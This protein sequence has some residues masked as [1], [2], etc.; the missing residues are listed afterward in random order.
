MVFNFGLPGVI[1]PNLLTADEGPAAPEGTSEPMLA[2]IKKLL[3]GLSNRS[4]ANG[5]PTGEELQ[6]AKTP[7]NE[8]RGFFNIL[9]NFNRGS[10]QRKVLADEATTAREKEAVD[11]DFKRASSE[12]L[13]ANVPLKAAQTSQIRAKI[14]QM[15]DELGLKQAASSR[16]L[17]KVINAASQKW[18]EIENEMQVETQKL[19]Q[20]G[21][22]AEARKLQAETAAARSEWEKKVADQRTVILN[23]NA[24]TGEARTAAYA[25]DVTNRGRYTDQLGK[26]ATQN[27]E[28]LR[29]PRRAQAEL[30]RANAQ[31]VGG[32]FSVGP[33]NANMKE[34][35]EAYAADKAG[36]GGT[37]IPEAVTGQERP[38]SLLDRLGITTPK[39]PIPVQPK[40]NNAAP[41]DA[42]PLHLLNERTPTTVR[43]PKTGQAEKWIIDSVTKQAKKV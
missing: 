41:V 3:A 24:K 12:N 9:E 35:A 34:V 14:A 6:L 38:Q 29:D 36:G 30:D 26:A 15:P 19:V 22:L 7:M 43:N 21:M 20:N 32:N 27:V 33:L 16:E 8:N 28:D 23:R 4:N 42:P 5:E 2:K 13:R 11:N 25:T 37:G 31:N 1:D 17:F 39:P 18:K 10:A 40:R